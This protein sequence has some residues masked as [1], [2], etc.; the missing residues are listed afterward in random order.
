MPKL[1]LEQST[2][3]TYTAQAGTLL[4]GGYLS[5]YSELEEL[6]AA[7]GPGGEVS[8]A[9]MLRTYVGL[10]AQGKSDFEA[11]ENVRDDKV[12]KLTL[13]IERVLS[14]SRLRQRFD[15]DARVLIEKVVVPCNTALLKNSKAP[16]TPIYTGHVVVDGDASPYDNSNSKKE[17]VSRTYKGFDG[18]NPMKVYMGQEGWCIA[19]ELRPGSWNGQ[20]E[21]LY[22][23]E[24]A[25]G[26]ARALTALPLL[27]RLDSQHDA[28]ANRVWIVDE[29]GDFII[30]VNPRKE[31]ADAWLAYAKQLGHW[32]TWASPRQG[33]QVGHFTVYVEAEVNGKQYTFRRVFRVVERTIDKKGQ[34]LL[35]PDVEVE[36]WWT[37]LELSDEEIIKLYNEH[38]TSEQYHSEFKTD[39]DLER[40]PSGK[41][42]TNDLV[43]N[44]GMLTYNIL[45]HIGLSGLLGDD[46]PVRHKA[47]RRRI[48]TVIQEMITVA[49]R[50]IERGRR[51]WLRFSKNC[52][53]YAAFRKVYDQLAYG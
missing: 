43:L 33:K 15:E 53:S 9:D 38:G 44:L 21:F 25:T 34:R 7:L 49:A 37:T 36:S 20:N 10:L 32:C 31:S 2:T 50:L 42:D 1:K 51:I 40:L 24:R 30:K 4:I 14:S 45:K 8:N 47:K 46:A 13:E 16:I 17:H 18:Y 12:F 29:E 27:W 19:A 23:L 11:V 35:V 48:K 5:N 3:E 39:L 41:F 22:V 26:V 6:C 28:L 52:A